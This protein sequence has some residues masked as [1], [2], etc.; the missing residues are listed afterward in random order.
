VLT[1]DQLRELCKTGWG[2]PRF[3]YNRTA[4]E[5]SYQDSVML[6][7]DKAMDDSVLPF[8]YEIKDPVETRAK[9]LRRGF[10]FLDGELAKLISQ[11]TQ[12][13]VYNLLAQH[14][15]EKCFDLLKLP[16]DQQWLALGVT[17]YFSAKYAGRADADAEGSMAGGDD[18]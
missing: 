12:P 5:V 11:Q 2:E 9:N 10:R 3:H 14:I 6:S 17:G 16:R 7:L 4:N 13:L 18:F 1:R 15:G 8:F